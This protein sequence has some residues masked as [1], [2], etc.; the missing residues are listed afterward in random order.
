MQI[1][2][3]LKLETEE[4][5]KL[6]EIFLLYSPRDDEG[7]AAYFLDIEKVPVGVKSKNKFEK[8]EVGMGLRL[9][10]QTALKLAWNILRALGESNE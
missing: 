7:E 10:K 1:S 8:V 3:R 4:H 6:G 2:E 9:T 5:A